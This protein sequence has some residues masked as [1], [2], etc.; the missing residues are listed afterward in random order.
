MSESKV[1]T[2]AIKLGL[3]AG[4]RRAV[5]EAALA[6]IRRDTF[7]GLRADGTRRD[8]TL[9][10]TGDLMDNESEAT[11]TGIR[12]KVPY[13]EEVNKK[14]PFTGIAPQEQPA[15]EEEIKDLVKNGVKVISEG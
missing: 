8:S 5:A 14:Q 11:D 7:Q 15:F 4:V 12:F 6:K 3:V 9:R 2:T 13:A 1:K 10:R